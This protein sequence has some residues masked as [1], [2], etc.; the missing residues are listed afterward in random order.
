MEGGWITTDDEY[1]YEILLSLRAHGW[2]RELPLNSKLRTIDEANWFDSQFEFVL[3]GLNF[4]PLEIE[5]AIGIVQLEKVEEMLQIRRQNADYFISK[6]QK[7]PKVRIQ[8][9]IGNSSWFA[10]ALLFQDQ[11]VRNHVAL[12]L[13]NSGIECRPIVTGN[14]T[15]QPV[16]KMLDHEIVGN[17]NNSNILHENG[18]Y[19]G[20]HPVFL[21]S[22]IDIL[23][24]VV[25]EALRET[26]ELKDK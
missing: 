1:L 17:L 6:F 5:A 16:M 21:N 18:L 10:F 24:Q 4:R 20:N 25:Y 26:E 3:P 7:V 8:N 13:R 9:P 11:G 23:F 15:R 2:T 19:V 14:F 12:K 22:E